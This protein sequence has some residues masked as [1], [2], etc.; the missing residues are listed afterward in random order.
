MRVNN[1]VVHRINKR[2][3]DETP[4]IVF[5]EHP[6]P[7]EETVTEFAEKVAKTYFEKKS[8]FYTRFENSETPPQFQERLDLLVNGSLSFYRFSR[9][10]SDILRERMQAIPQ[11][12]GGFLVIMDYVSSSG[13]RYLFIGLLNNKEDFSINDTLEIIKNLTLNIDHMAMAGVVNLD[14]YINQNGDYITFLRGLRN[15]PDYF[16]SF[17]GA[18]SDRRRDIREVTSRWAYAIRE[19]FEH[20]DVNQET[21]ESIVQQLLETIKR[22]NR[23]EEI[24]TAEVI[25]NTIAP[26]NPESFLEFVYDETRDFQ[27]P[28]EMEKL[29][30]SEI[31]KLSIISYVDNQKGFKISL[32]A[33]MYGTIIMVENGRVIID[34]PDIASGIEHAAQT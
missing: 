10:I 9:Q 20:S 34:D 23:S 2:E 33:S 13:I 15:I 19:Y 3:N 32:K 27:L 7:L 12:R 30:T 18:D 14:K 17:I 4:T 8:R 22:I 1:I 24:I 28:S 29:D 6:L 16:I 11:S 31:R 5:S 26:E 25:A 21:E